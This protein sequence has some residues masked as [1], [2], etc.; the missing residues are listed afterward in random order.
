MTQYIKFLVGRGM[1]TEKNIDEHKK[2]VW[3]MLETAVDGAKD[4][5]PTSKEWLS[6]SWPGFPS[7]KQLAEQV[8]PMRVFT[9]P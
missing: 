5:I 7:P 2:W 8:F 1:F 6:A 3:G 9:L 4:Y